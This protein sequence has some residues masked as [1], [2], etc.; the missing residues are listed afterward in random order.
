MKNYS[1]LILFLLFGCQT[2]YE[3]GNH[4]VGNLRYDSIGYIKT[5]ELGVNYYWNGF[6]Q[7]T[8]NNEN[9]FIG[10]NLPRKTLDIIHLEGLEKIFQVNIE[11][12]G[13]NGIVGNFIGIKGGEN[14]FYILTDYAF[15][16]AELSIDQK[17]L[18][19][20]RKIT[21]SNDRHGFGHT[22][23]NSVFYPN[24]PFFATNEQFAFVPFYLS[25]RPGDPEHFLEPNL[26]M[27]NLASQ[28]TSH[29]FVE[30]PMPS[31]YSNDTFF[32]PANQRFFPLQV[33]N[34]LYVSYPFTSLI[35]KIDFNGQKLVSQTDWAKPI[36]DLEKLIRK[37][38][39]KNSEKF[40]PAFIIDYGN[41]GHFLP[42]Q[43]NSVKK[44]FFR[45]FLNPFDEEEDKRRIR[46]REKWLLEYTS[47]GD[48]MSK[49][50]IPRELEMQPLIRKDGS[51]WFPKR[52]DT[53]EYL[54]FAIYR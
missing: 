49:T 39:F 16:I 38:S 53:E 32:H 41:N 9:Y 21:L 27:V 17:K 4:E 5:S 28:D 37:S 13:P 47:K 3:V 51:Y 31:L 24:M 46:E 52:S 54:E 15:Y 45:V 26:L 34:E 12:E 43:Y 40:D 19:V 10:F 25:S 44:C 33:G 22:N 1:I 35:S 7:A 18:I 29:S 2:Q 30:W 36:D 11:R 42:L 50:L 48:L 6:T 23:F 8:I 20:Q 14:R